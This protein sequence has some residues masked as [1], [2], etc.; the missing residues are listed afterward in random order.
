MKKLKKISP[1]APEKWDKK[2]TKALTEG[3]LQEIG[4]LQNLLYAERQRSILIILQGM[5]G[6][7]KDSTIK[8]LF[9][10]CSVAGVKVH[11]FKR[12]TEEETEH[13]FLWRVHQVAPSKGMIQVFNRSHYEDV[14]IHRVHGWIDAERV[15]KRINAINAF[16]ELLVFDNQTTILKFYMHISHEEQYQQ[17]LERTQNPEKYWKHSDDDWAETKRWDEYMAAYEDLFDRCTVP[18]VILPCNQAWYRDYV[19]AKTLRDT[20]KSLNMQFPKLQTNLERYEL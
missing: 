10:T 15:T 12:P 7:G 3:L 19:I 1:D 9:G 18:W 5:D 16:E 6:S 2:A 14:L 13:D 11:A 20:L 8:H 17:L 4:D